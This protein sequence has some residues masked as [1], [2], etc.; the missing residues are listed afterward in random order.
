MIDM[1][2]S[3]DI[4]AHNLKAKLWSPLSIFVVNHFHE[5]D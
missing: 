4:P 1:R 2:L 5:L 3:S